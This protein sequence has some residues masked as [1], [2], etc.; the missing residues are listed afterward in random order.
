MD[1]WVCWCLTRGFTL[2]AQENCEIK[3]N[4]RFFLQNNI[5]MLHHHFRQIGIVY[6]YDRHVAD[7]CTICYP[8]SFKQH[9]KMVYVFKQT[10]A[11]V[12]NINTLPTV[13]LLSSWKKLI[14][15]LRINLETPT[16]SKDSWKG[17][18]FPTWSCMPFQSGKSREN[19]LEKNFR[20]L[21]IENIW[22]LKN[23]KYYIILYVYVTFITCVIDVHSCMVRYLHCDL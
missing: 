10:V 7:S 22:F 16:I 14:P 19:Q 8:I 6:V 9:I 17:R 3:E 12:A 11:W 4:W 5:M 20:C 1:V 21:M 2:N 23:M 13:Q 15:T 18:A